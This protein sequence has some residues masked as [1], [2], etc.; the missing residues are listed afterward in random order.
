MAGFGSN[1]NHPGSGDGQGSI[2]IPVSY[3]TGLVEDVIYTNKSGSAGTLAY[4]PDGSNLG[5]IRVRLIP[6]Q[7]GTPKTELDTA[8]PVNY[9]IQDFPLVGE[10]VLVFKDGTGL[11]YTKLAHRKK[12]TENRDDN[13][14]RTYSNTNTA[15]EDAVTSRQLAASGVPT[16]YTA[17]DI[18]QSTDTFVENPS[19]RGVRPYEGDIIY[20]GRYGNIIRFGS[21]KFQNPDVILPEPNIFITAGLNKTPKK[22]TTTEITPYSLQEEDINNDKSSIWMVTDQDVAFVPVTGMDGERSVNYQNPA[23]NYSGPQIFINSDRVVLNS[24]KQEISL[25]AKTQ[26]NLN[27][28]GSISLR[29]DENIAIN[30]IRDIEIVATRGL[31]LKAADLTLLGSKNLSIRTAGDYGISGQ[32]IFIGTYGDATQPMVCGTNLGLYMGLLVNNLIALNTALTAV[33]SAL[34]SATTPGGT[35]P[36]PIP[37]LVAAGPALSSALVPI[38]TQL[39]T[40]LVGSGFTGPIPGKGAIFNSKSNFVSIGTTAPE[41]T[42]V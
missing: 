41:E 10:K 39:A 15:E 7:W 22:V 19:T 23:T 38:Q 37:S 18:T 24:K 40:L 17:E 25:F 13:A 30:A 42:T 16:N 29:T 20:Q 31:T 33:A 1:L 21:S 2:S 14:R 27:S 26:I 32:R 5:E 4:K 3:F 9:N 12:I 8:T 34:G 11:Y 35:T 36:A 28:F 6:T